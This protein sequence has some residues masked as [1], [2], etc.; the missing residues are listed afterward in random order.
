MSEIRYVPASLHYAVSYGAAV[1]AVA[2]ERKYLGS[3]E[4]FPP[5][6][7]LA[8]VRNI[9][10]NNFAQY[11]ALEGERVIGWCDIIPKSFEGMRHVG[12]LGMGV[13]ATY[14]NMGIGKKLLVLAIKHA[15]Q[16][17]GI[18]K[19]E[20]EVF[21]TNVDAI[22]LYEKFGFRHEGTRVKGRKLDGVYDDIVLMGKE[23]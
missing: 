8:F 1:D 14:R 3:T 6:S 2:R 4:G 12:V 11:Y 22:R 5:E 13:L 7:T 21:K 18:E 19:V 17:N 20:L 9:E 10:E 16:H 15:R 23:L